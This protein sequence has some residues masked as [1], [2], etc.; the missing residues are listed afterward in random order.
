MEPEGQGD[1]TV[2]QPQ[3]TKVLA[4]SLR[5]AARI[6]PQQTVMARVQVDHKSA[7]GVGNLAGIVIPKEEVLAQNQCVQYIRSYEGVPSDQDAPRF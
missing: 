5:H 4:I 2:A 1:N 7:V 6:R 3:T